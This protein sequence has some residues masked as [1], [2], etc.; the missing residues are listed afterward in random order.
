MVEGWLRRS[1]PIAHWRV[2]QPPRQ[3]VEPVAP[4][5]A[6]AATALPAAVE[7]DCSPLLAAD[8]DDCSHLEYS[9]KVCCINWN[10]MN[11]EIETLW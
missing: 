9:K 10:E 2:K 5:A 8:E 1:S 4:A 6:A 11:F 3:P 7:D